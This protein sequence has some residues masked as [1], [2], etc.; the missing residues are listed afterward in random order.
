MNCDWSANR[1]V[2]HDLPNVTMRCVGVRLLK[3]YFH[4]RDRERIAQLPPPERRPDLVYHR[5]SARRMRRMRTLSS[6]VGGLGTIARA[7]IARSTV[8]L[9]SEAASCPE[10]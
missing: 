8:Y 10:I 9:R 4:E 6:S 5:S 7:V 3:Q 2:Q 1:R